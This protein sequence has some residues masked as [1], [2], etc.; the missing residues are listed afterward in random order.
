[1]SQKFQ[2]PANRPVIV[3]FRTDLRIC[4]NGALA[5]AVA[6]GKPVIAAYVLDE[7]GD[8]RP[9]GAA[10]KWWLH[11]SLTA[12]GAS[13]GKSGV[14]LVLRRASMQEAAEDLIE[15][16]GAD[17][18]LWNRRY[19]PAGMSADAAM[20]EKLRQRG[21]IAKSF[22]GHLLHHP[23]ALR[24]SNGGQFRIFSPFWRA[25]EQTIDPAPPIPAP[26]RIKA[27]DGELRSESLNDWGYL[28]ATPDWAAGMR[29]Q[30]TPGE[31][32]ANARLDR[33]LQGTLAGYASR[34]DIP[35]EV[36]TSRLSPHLAHGE[37][38]PRQ[39]LYAI[40]RKSG[41]VDGSDVSKFRKEV[42][43]REFAYHLLFHNPC[44][45]TE[46]YNRAFDRFPWSKPESGFDRWKAGQTGYPIVDAGMRELWQTGWIHNRVRMV[47]ASF[48]VKHLLIDWR[49]GETWFWDTLVDAD[50]ANNPASWQWVAGSGADAA[51]YFRVFNPVLQGKKFDP[52]GRYVRRYVPELSNLSHDYIHCPWEAPQGAL[53]KAGVSLGSTYP[54]PIVNHKASRDRALGAYRKIRERA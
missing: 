44:L 42:G 51:P 49:I 10:S 14:K 17:A 13:L 43:W 25:L 11:H 22:E 46:N 50:P 1:M 27:Y 23:P 39:I 21:V 12:L 47:A 15:Q 32:G 30:W 26:R 20:K 37:I 16:T 53:E 4:D 35:G 18:V 6:T 29:A 34:R 5:A 45:D 3:L 2:N 48:L 40:S 31:T 8:G 36:T 38:T 24:P 7:N 28:P 33:F 19:F 54:R 41:E 52:E 9:T